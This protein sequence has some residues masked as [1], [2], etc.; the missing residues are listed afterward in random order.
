MPFIAL[1][2]II[3]IAIA[4]I[5]HISPAFAAM[6]CHIIIDCYVFCFRQAAAIAIAAAA[7][8]RD[9]IEILIVAGFIRISSSDELAAA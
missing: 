4:I 2:A 1:I 6:P 7:R 8:S 9:L 3:A 5:T